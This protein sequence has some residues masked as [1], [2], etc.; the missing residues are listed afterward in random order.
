MPLNLRN[1]LDLTTLRIFIAVAE[2]GNLSKAAQRENIASSAASKRLS[3]LEATLETIL[4]YRLPRGVE[5]TPAGTVLAQHARMILDGVDRLEGELT[6]YAK[7]VRGHVRI[8]VNKSAVVARLPRDLKLFL[9]RYPDVKIDLQE[10]NSGPIVKSVR[11]GHSDIG[12]YVVGGASTE[13]LET[14]AYCTDHLGVIVPTRHPLAQR[15]AISFEE[16]LA[17]DLIGYDRTTALEQLLTE[18]AASLDAAPKVRFRV[19]SLDAACR[20]VAAELGVTIAPIDVIKPYR[21]EFGLQSLRL[22]NGWADRKIEIVVRSF[23]GL[24]MPA[25]MM[26][27]H[28]RTLPGADPA[29]DGLNSIEQA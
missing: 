19:A 18:S 11:D 13:G 8:T 22:E 10:E 15:T 1:R 16:V 9:E 21:Q 24:S 7:G 12:I 25:R 4:L 26:V 17:Y 27:N 5:L 23:D 20:M 28:L 3:D 14:C 6:D 29:V 2:T